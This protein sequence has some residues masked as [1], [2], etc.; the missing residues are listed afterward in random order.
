MRREGMSAEDMGLL[1]YLACQRKDKNLVFSAFPD[2]P[3]YVTSS[4]EV[5]ESIKK[6]MYKLMASTGGPNTMVA[7][8]F[9]ARRQ[10]HRN[11]REN[12]W[13]W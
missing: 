5:A 10:S 1:T 2:A 4:R 12:R 11:C 7:S 8:K 13:F 6:S 3:M 9:T